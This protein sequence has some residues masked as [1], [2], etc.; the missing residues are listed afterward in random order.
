MVLPFIPRSRTAAEQADFLAKTLADE[1]S[2][3]E[4]TI[5]PLDGRLGPSN[6]IFPAESAG[7]AGRAGVAPNNCV[8]F[9][10]ERN[11]DRPE[12]V[13]V[14][15]PSPRSSSASFRVLRC[16]DVSRMPHTN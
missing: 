13:L 6:H 3:E 11:G 8:T 2:S 5:L 10:L 1:I 7:W 9:R 4:R 16:D 15:K 12:V 14:Q